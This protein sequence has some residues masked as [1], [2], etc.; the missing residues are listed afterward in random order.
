M[1]SGPFPLA[2]FRSHIISAALTANLSLMTL[3]TLQQS[4]S[5]KLSALTVRGSFILIIERKSQKGNN[6]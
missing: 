2:T 5:E 3:W 4:M 6:S 1:L